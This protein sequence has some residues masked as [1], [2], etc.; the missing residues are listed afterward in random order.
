MKIDFPHLWSYGRNIMK[1]ILFTFLLLAFVAVNAAQKK[2]EASDFSIKTNKVIELPP[3]LREKP[4]LHLVGTV[5]N[6]SVTSFS[7]NAVYFSV[8][9]SGT[10]NGKTYFP[11]R[12]TQGIT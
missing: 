3:M 1:R 10:G 12:F 8:Q 6:A 2:K 9:H 7:L 11:C 5:V 4:Q